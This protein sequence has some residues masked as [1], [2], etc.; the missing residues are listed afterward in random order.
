VRLWE[1][2]ELL[3]AFGQ[4]CRTGKIDNRD[5]YYRLYG[6]GLVRKEGERI[7]PANHLYARYFGNA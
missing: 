2:P 7:E 3:E 4:A 6:A 1:R 5:A